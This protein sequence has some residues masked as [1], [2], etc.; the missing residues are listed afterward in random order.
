LNKL[1][2]NRI[3]SSSRQPFPLEV[4]VPGFPHLVSISGKALVNWSIDQIL[5]YLRNGL[6]H[7]KNERGVIPSI[8]IASVQASNHELAINIAKKIRSIHRFREEFNI[9]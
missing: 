8:F 6:N 9:N 7:F 3:I 2:F 4:I 5:D 1:P